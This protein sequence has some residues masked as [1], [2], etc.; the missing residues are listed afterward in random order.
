MMMRH[1]T[2]GPQRHELSKPLSVETFGRQDKYRFACSDDENRP[3]SVQ[4]AKAVDTGCCPQ[5]PNKAGLCP[6]ALHSFREFLF[7]SP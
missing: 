2:T 5:L 7:L 6:S 4:F 3:S 1:G